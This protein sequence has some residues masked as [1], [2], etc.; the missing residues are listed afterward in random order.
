MNK[1]R[2]SEPLQ[3]SWRLASDL[4]GVHCQS[5]GW[6]HGLWQ[7]LRVIG[8]GK[9]LSGQSDWFFEHIERYKD[10][11]EVSILISGCA[12]YSAFAHVVAALGLPD[13][14]RKVRIVA[15][16]RCRTPLELNA[17][18]SQMTGV[19]I[20]NQV[21][22]ALKFESDIQ[23]DLIFTSSFL[24][25]FNPEERVQL[26]KK[27]RQLLAPG[28]EL[29]VSNRTKD[30]PEDVKLHF[31]PD[32]ADDAVKGALDLNRLCTTPHKMTDDELEERMRNYVRGWGTYPINSA[33]RLEATIRQAGFTDFTLEERMPNLPQTQ[34]KLVGHTFAER[35]P[36]LCVVAKRSDV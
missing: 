13:N 21:A 35:T 19:P 26:F 22:D 8:M 11:K 15:I 2:V 18:Y 30:K 32:V 36:F 10:R 9:T 3:E 33:A 23:F 16:D 27:Y 25:F 31:A 17:Y 1:N 34:V 12:D 28:G 24:G 5:C 6:Y 4:A 7:Y 29:V 14:T 20:E